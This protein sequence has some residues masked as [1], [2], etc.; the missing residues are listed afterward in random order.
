[1][2]ALIPSLH[3]TEPEVAGEVVM[4]E[5]S[6]SPTEGAVAVHSAEPS[7]LATAVASE[8]STARADE[9]VVFT[10][11]Y[12][13]NL[14]DPR[15]KT[16]WGFACLVETSGQLILFDTGGDGEILLANLKTLGFDPSRIDIVVLSHIHADHVG[17]LDSLLAENDHLVVYFP[18]SF[19]DSFAR[20]V[21]ERAR[22]VQVAG[23]MKIMDGVETTGEMGTTIREQSLIVETASGLV[24]VTG[25]A[26]PGIVNI[27][28]QAAT[29]G[30]IDLLIGGFH[31]IDRSRKDVQGVIEELL[32]LG[33]RRIAPC[34]CTGTAA[35][36]QFEDAYGSSFIPCGVGTVIT[37]GG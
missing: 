25:C 11:V 3:E 32:A 37:I 15:L 36:V 17:G 14:F 31:L 21:S 34:H 1:M 8:T 29:R 35:T 26:H 6:R 16:A 9:H 2:G 23:P 13:N 12:D 19:P 22:V 24:V 30:E 4:A 33:V 20:R 5:P 7:Q 10:V 18:A 28:R 27:A